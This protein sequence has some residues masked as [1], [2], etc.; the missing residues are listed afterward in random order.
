MKFPASTLL[1]VLLAVTANFGIWASLNRPQDPA[2]DWRG[3]IRGV[4]FNPMRKSDDPDDGRLPNAAQ[5]EADLTLLSGKVSA[6]RTYGISGDLALIP[7]LAAKHNINV[8]LGAWIGPD[9][10]QNEQEIRRLIGAA[11]DEPNVR[12]ILVGNETLLRGD[13]PASELI[14]YIRRVQQATGHRVST[15][16]PWQVWL[17]NP[18]LA[19]TADFIAVH[20]LPYWEGMS[21]DGAVDYVF[22]RYRELQHAYPDKPIVL[23]EV[24]WP[25]SGPAIGR[26][27]ASLVNEAK[28]TRN[29]LNRVQGTDIDYF[30]VEAFDQPWKLAHEGSAGAYWGLYNANRE[31]KFP[32]QGEVLAMPSWNRWAIMAILLAFIPASYFVLKRHGIGEPGKA[33]FALVSNV[34]ASGIAWTASL[35]F[36]HYQ[37]PLSAMTWIVLVVMQVLALLVLLTE[38]IEAAEV[39]WRKGAGRDFSVL[40]RTPDYRYP[41]V[42][43]HV[44]VHNE[45]PHLVRATLEALSRLEYPD[46]EVLV[47]DN[48]TPDSATW[49]PVQ[50]TCSELG[51]RFRFF[52]L[53]KWP[54]FKAGALNF[55]LRQTAAD[56]E[57]VAVVDSDYVVS[58]RW[59]AGLTPYF[60][61]PGV[62]FVQAPQDYRDG[63]DN[64]FKRLC[65]WEYAGF[66]R[67]GMVQRN[68]FNAIIQHG[69]MT[70]IRKDALHR[71]GQWGEWCICEDAELGLRLLTHGMDS[72]YVPQ[73][74]GRGVMPDTLSAYKTQRFRWAYGAVQIMKHH[75]R[76]LL[77]WNGGTLSAAQKYYFVAGWLP[78]LSDG[79]ALVFT[80]TSLLVTADVV[81]RFPL[82]DFPVAAFL[83]P[84]VGL[85]GFKLARSIWLYEDLVRCGFW[86]SVGAALAGLSL[87]HTVGRA[88]LAGLFTSGR[89]FVRTPKLEAG[90]PLTSA[91]AMVYQELGLMLLLWIAAVAVSAQDEFHNSSGDLWVSILLVQSLPYLAAV[92]MA[93]ANAASVAGSAAAPDQAAPA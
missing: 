91:L 43:I 49:V 75:L 82:A 11:R 59:L 32:M 76:A 62:G 88:V 93:L 90:R 14:T 46:F 24:G 89:P 63:S 72:V 69:T 87:S 54:G 56:A 66:F 37:T 83:M 6:V 9:R 23:A 12:R 38:T 8:T 39:I 27:R 44:P 13:I 73:S 71:A 57:I 64:L 48:N 85:F 31:L 67:I 7:V 50:Q 78:W 22:M 10:A 17:S 26:A 25:S 20:V 52:H 30:I 79:L 41:K 34:A 29:F 42:S 58:P 15:A 2:A 16:E 70:L 77:P 21:V 86:N 53:E 1:A 60:D 84:T 81:A 61:N 4:S 65:Y 40:N 68:D 55:A 19:H 36:T 80:T 74:L 3:T 51:P 33:L 28:F 92:I 5:I 47:V 45:P 18:E 35:G